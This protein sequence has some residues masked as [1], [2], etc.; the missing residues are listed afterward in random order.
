LN[1]DTNYKQHE[2]DVGKFYKVDP[3]KI[4]STLKYASTL[5][6]NSENGSRKKIN[7]KST[8]PINSTKGMNSAWID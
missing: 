8:S 6:N 4:G 1:K 7:V 2:F 5:R 3:T